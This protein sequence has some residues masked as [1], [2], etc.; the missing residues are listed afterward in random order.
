MKVTLHRAGSLGL[1]G[2]VTLK[3]GGNEVS[4]DQWDKVKDHPVVKD[5]LRKATH[6]GLT[7]SEATDP[8]REPAPKAPEPAPMVDESSDADY[9]GAGRS[10]AKETRAM[11]ERMESI[12]DLDELEE[13]EDRKTVLSAID[14]RRAELSGNED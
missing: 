10:S 13:T 4:Q 3:S 9:S 6:G 1:M 7:V 14:A 5:A 11:V 8:V 12:A 2:V